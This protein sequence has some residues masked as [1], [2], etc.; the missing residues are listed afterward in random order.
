MN[1]PGPT[2]EQIIANLEANIR[3]ARK[4]SKERTFWELQLEREHQRQDPEHQQRLA[5]A[6]AAF[7]ELLPKVS[8]R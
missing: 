7:P 5:D 8:S 3:K 1:A 2:P 4:G 6:Y